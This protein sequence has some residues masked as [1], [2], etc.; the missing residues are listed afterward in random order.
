VV[1]LKIGSLLDQM[2][3]TTHLGHPSPQF[4]TRSTGEDIMS[5]M[6]VSTGRRILFLL[7]QGLG[8][9]SLKIALIFL[10]MTFLTFLIIVEE[11]GNSAEKLWVRMFHTFFL[12]V[13]MTFRTGKPAMGRG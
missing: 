10:G 5:H 2:T 4:E 11:G 13:C 12:E 3:G 1:V 8:M 6:T 9:S 7:H